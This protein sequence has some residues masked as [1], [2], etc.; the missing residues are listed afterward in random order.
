MIKCNNIVN[1]THDNGGDKEGERY[2]EWGIG[3]E[4]KGNER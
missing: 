2:D 4:R 3:K 1:G